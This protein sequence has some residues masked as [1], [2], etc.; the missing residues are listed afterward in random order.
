MVAKFNNWKLLQGA[1]RT[2]ENCFQY[3]IRYNLVLIMKHLQRNQP[4]PL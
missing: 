2:E 4:T 3:G 1:Q